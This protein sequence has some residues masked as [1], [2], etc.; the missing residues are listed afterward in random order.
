MRS[1][2]SKRL[3]AAAT[4]SGPR[5]SD[6]LAGEISPSVRQSRSTAKFYVR[7]ISKD[8]TTELRVLLTE[9]RGQRKV[10]LRDYTAVIPG[11]YFPAGAGVTLPLDKLDE[12][13]DALKAVR[14]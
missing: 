14:R 6:L 3:A 13:I 1:P 2:H 8:Q 7:S 9:W 11:C 5:K 12:L 4:A 10:E